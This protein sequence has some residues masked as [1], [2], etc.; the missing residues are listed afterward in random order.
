MHSRGGDARL[1]L[2]DTLG[3]ESP[4]IFRVFEEASH[5]DVTERRAEQSRD[6]GFGFRLQPGI[7]V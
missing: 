2:D 4:G 1:R 7:A 3:D 6:V 5:E